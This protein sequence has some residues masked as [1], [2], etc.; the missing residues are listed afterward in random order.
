MKKVAFS[1]LAALVTLT[2]CNAITGLGHD[3]SNAG[4]EVSETAQET[5]QKI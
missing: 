4:D 3:I 5:K 2:G 1:T